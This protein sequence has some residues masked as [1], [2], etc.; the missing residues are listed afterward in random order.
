MTM[1]DS[2]R[3]PPH[4]PEAERRLI[5]AAMLYADRALMNALGLRSDEF[6]LPMHRDAWAAIRAAEKRDGAVLDPITLEPEIKA[7]GADRHFPEGWMPWALEAYN[8]ACLPEQVEHYATMVRE[9]Y[10]K[11]RLISLC[12]DL[13][14]AAYSETQTWGEVLEAARLGIGELEMAGAATNTTH[15]YQPMVELLDEIDKR[16][17]GIKPELVTTSIATLDEVVDGFEGGQ[18]IIVAARPGQ[19]KTALACNIAAA[20]ALRLVPCLVFSLEMRMRKIARRIL[21]WHTKMPGALMNE[22]NVEQ[23]N[24]IRDGVGDFEHATLWL[25]DKTRRLG[26]IVSEACRWHAKHVMGKSKRATVM[27]DYAQLIRTTGQ[28][29]RNREQEVAEISQTMKGLAMHLDVPVVLLAQLNRACETRGGAPMLSD[30]R[31]SGAIEQD[32]DMVLFPYRDIPAT[33]Q[34]K[35]NQRGPGQIIVA[36]NRDGRIGAANIEWIP[37]LMTF[38]SPTDERAVEPN[39]WHEGGSK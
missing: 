12:V 16:Q 1:N 11:R 2:E 24:K 28:K 37:E 7:A 14:N 36:K 31:E 38:L 13:Q 5:G 18:L 15:V 27:V 21:I 30:L 17:Q 19:G 29:G 4:H 9:S 26:Q 34:D 6:F 8:L 33:D 20:N 32:A 39:D 23:W 22:A 3:I 25:N 35:R 10:S